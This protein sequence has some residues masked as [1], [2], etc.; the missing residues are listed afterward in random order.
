MSDPSNGCVQCR[1]LH[2]GIERSKTE[3][4]RDAKRLAALPHDARKSRGHG[5]AAHLTA[6][7]GATRARLADQRA[8]QT[9]HRATCPK[10][11]ARQG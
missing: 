10:W 5:T 9:Q 1:T 3:L 2:L 6:D 11:A 7:I 8:A 4:A